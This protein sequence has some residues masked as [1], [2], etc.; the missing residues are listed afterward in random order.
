[1]P[2]AKVMRTYEGDVNSASGE[3]LKEPSSSTILPKA[4]FNGHSIEETLN[5]KFAQCKTSHT[6]KIYV[7]KLPDNENIGKVFSKFFFFLFIITYT[8]TN[9]TKIKKEK[10][11]IYIYI[12][13][14]I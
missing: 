4:S 11:Y 13:V 8:S 14:H 9:Y 5:V 7:F 2:F 1:M 6:L 10:I 3:N 12:Y